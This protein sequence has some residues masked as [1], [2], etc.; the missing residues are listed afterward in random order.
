M[1]QVAAPMG[2]LAAAHP[3]GEI[4]QA[5]LVDGILSGYA[6]AI[7]QN[8]PIKWDV[9]GTIIPV[10]ANNDPVMGVFAGCEFTR[11]DGSRA[12]LPYWPAAQTYIAGSCL[13]KFVPI[14]DADAIF[15]GQTNA[16]V[17]VTAR[18]QGINLVTGNPT[19]SVQ[20][21]LSSQALGALTGATAA[22]FQVLD[23]VNQPDNAW[24]DPYVWLYVK[25]ANPQGLVA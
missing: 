15:I 16:T 13:A 17:G 20:T 10:V 14:V 24:G 25:I 18:G 19:G 8:S 9:N 7:Y 22:S 11:L 23:F 1:S 12:V 21:G 5:N 6:N 3:S 4:R 2:L